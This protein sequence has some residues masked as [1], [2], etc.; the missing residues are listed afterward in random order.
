MLLNLLFQQP[1]VAILLLLAIIVVISV[2]EYSH[3]LAGYLLGDKTAEH[4][5]RLTL[6]PLSHLDLMGSLML[7]IVGFGWGRP[8][9]FN[10]YNLRW[11]KWG[12]AAVSLAGPVSNFI[13]AFVFAGIL[14]LI[15]PTYGVDNYLTLFLIFLVM[16]SVG[17][18]LF[19]L[20]PIPPL[21]GSR[22]LL[23]LLPHRY[24]WLAIWL[25]RNGFWLLIGLLIVL[26]F[27]DQGFFLHVVNAILG[28]FGLQL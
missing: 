21:D 1:G 4:E 7:I 18:G 6:N 13:M 9:P 16:Y 22:V 10:P 27:S 14:A 28:L 24:D 3:A 26:Q 19:N 8:V 5:G 11:P 20:I 12:P 2:H 25:Q 23:T 15:R 17:L